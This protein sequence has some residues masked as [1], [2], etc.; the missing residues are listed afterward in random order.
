MEKKK[1]YKCPIC[2]L[3][4][5]AALVNGNTYGDNT[6]LISTSNSPMNAEDMCGN[7]NSSFEED[8]PRTSS[9]LWDE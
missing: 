5:L 1:T 4:I 3:I 8:I 7:E 6:G 9:S 2:E